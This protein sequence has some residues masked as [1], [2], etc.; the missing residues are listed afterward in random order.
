[1]IFI[2]LRNCLIGAS[3]LMVMACAATFENA[4]AQWQPP[5]E[6]EIAKIAKTTENIFVYGKRYRVKLYTEVQPTITWKEAKP[7][8]PAEIKKVYK[9]TDDQVLARLAYL[10][11]QKQ[12]E[13]ETGFELVLKQQAALRKD[14]D[15]DDISLEL[16]EEFFTNQ[17]AQYSPE[18]QYICNEFQA[19]GYLHTMLYIAIKRQYPS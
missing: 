13:Y 9:M 4:Q 2:S 5:S 19:L 16:G 12:K 8:L 15:I 1:M 6:K 17:G 7:Y 14:E 18:L 11:K 3:V 10:Q